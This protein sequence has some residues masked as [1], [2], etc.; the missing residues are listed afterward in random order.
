M[1]KTG[2]K[3]LD[4]ILVERGIVSSREQAQR[5]I[6][7]GQVRLGTDVLD[8]PGARIAADA[9]LEVRDLHDRFVSRGGWK[10]QA[11]IDAFPGLTPCPRVC[12][13]IGASTGGF[14]DCLLQHGAERVYA[15]DVGT[16]QLDARLRADPRVVAMEKTNARYLTA[17]SLPE[18]VDLVVGDVSF[19]SL[20][21]ILPAAETLLRPD[22]EKQ[23]VVL[24][25]PQ[26]EAGPE[27][28]GKGGVVRD[29]EVH[30]SV[31]RR[32]VLEVLPSLGLVA[33]GPIPSP[34]LGPAGNREYL[35]YISNLSNRPDAA[36]AVD[37]EA[38]DR[39]VAAAFER[40]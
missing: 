1:A 16:S 34:I 37:S 35:L 18:P 29:P 22:G 3:R 12:A 7:A 17:E 2:K 38:I 4:L 30:R 6:R 5:V 8:K 32:I 40:V 26:F 14:T 39:A 19:I 24:V 21:K 23:M 9:D 20:E 28:V 25:K 13:D 33:A 10:L 11:A 15:I 31:L 27:K 36:L